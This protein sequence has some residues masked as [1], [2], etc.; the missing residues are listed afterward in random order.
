M[1]QKEQQKD[2][3]C[4][5]QIRKIQ[6]GNETEYY[7]DRGL[8]LKSNEKTEDNEDPD[9]EF[10]NIKHLIGPEQKN[11]VV[12]PV[13]LIGPT[14]AF[15]HCE[16]H[17][18]RR[19][20]LAQVR[21]YFF[22]PKMRDFVKIFLKGCDL[23]ARHSPKFHK[24][25]PGHLVLPEEKLN[26]WSLDIVT[27][28]TPYNGNDSFLS[29]YEHFSNFRIMVPCKNT[30]TAKR[31]AAIIDDRILS[32]FGTPNTLVSDGGPQ[33]L[34]SQLLQ[35]YCRHRGINTKITLPHAPQTHGNIEAAHREGQ[36]LLR[37]IGE[38]LEANMLKNI[39]YVC[40]TLNRKPISDKGGF[41]A[42]EIMFGKEE[43]P[44]KMLIA[45]NDLRSPSEKR[46]QI[47]E[48]EKTVSHAIRK[49]QSAQLKEL[50]TA[51]QPQYAEGQYVMERNNRQMT[52]KKTRHRF[53]PPP[54]KVIREYP[55]CVVVSDTF[56]RIRTLHKQNVK[57][58]P[59]RD[60]KM[61]KA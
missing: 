53:L 45:E 51:P 18:G 5:D 22:F 29:I 19:I 10:T 50:R 47:L 48:I 16:N 57:P 3:F 1:H 32:T 59:E 42:S 4:Q 27:G 34:N 61:F 13:S 55:Q 25:S 26:T 21:R 43:P 8:L 60:D 58:L 38:Q 33:L 23:C 31:V 49:T 14:L 54:L 40:N 41:S 17:G 46:R 52:K 11:K 15:F 35:E 30:I 36:R 44:L 39:N 24:H 28:L 6:E 2:P 7:L 20:L 37:I 9:E 12:T 56:Q